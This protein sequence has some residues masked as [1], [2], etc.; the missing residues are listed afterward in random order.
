MGDSLA[1]IDT[2]RKLEGIVPPFLRGRGG[3][4]GSLCNTMWPGPRPTFIPSDILIHPAVWPQQTWAKSC[5][6]SC[7]PWGGA[8]SAFNTMLPGSRPIFVPSGILI[9][10]FGHNRHGPRIGG[11]CPFG[12]PS[13]IIWPEPR[14]TI[15]LHAKFYLDPSNRLATIHQR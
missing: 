3:G 10:T 4:A 11:L 6:S 1:T 9:Q 7:A 8:G 12:S 5:W 2:D 13:N 15:Y 14:P